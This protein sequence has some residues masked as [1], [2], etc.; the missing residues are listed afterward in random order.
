MNKKLRAL[1]HSVLFKFLDETSG[2]TGSFSER[3]RSGLI[4]PKLKGTQKGERWGEVLVIGPDVK[5]VLVGDYILI[6][7]LM[8]T[9]GEVF[10]GTKVW[11]TN[12]DVIM[13]VSNDL[14][15]TVQY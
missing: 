12:T 5:G 9:M 10:E 14:A 13:A 4:I 11:K 6:E 3:T 15:D 7:P 1:N 2:Q 8:W